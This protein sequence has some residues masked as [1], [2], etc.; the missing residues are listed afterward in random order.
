MKHPLPR[1]LVSVLALVLVLSLLPL[2]ALAATNVYQDVFDGRD[3]DF[4]DYDR[5]VSSTFL[6]GIPETGH[7]PYT[8]SAEDYDYYIRQDGEVYEF[9]GMGSVTAAGDRRIDNGVES[10]T[11]PVLPASATTEEVL[12]WINEYWDISLAYGPH[13]HTPFQGKWFSN[14]TN[15]WQVCGQC[16]TVYNMNWHWDLDEDGICDDCGM[17]I[18]RYPITL[19][20]VSGGSLTL[21][22]KDG[23]YN[24]VVEVTVEAAPG[25][26]LR[27]LH[28]YRL[29]GEQR[30]ELIRWE[31]APGTQYHFLMPFYPVV[32]EAEFEKN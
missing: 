16:L 15:H 5:V 3:A 32:I 9:L 1:S 30:F 23:A 6:E 31:D 8:I 21:S 24:D 28:F 20:E 12:A 27:Q 14:A 29:E 22:Q 26:A 17:E 10:I 18:L 25:Y 7:G 4:D 2:G 19:P 11:V 13:K